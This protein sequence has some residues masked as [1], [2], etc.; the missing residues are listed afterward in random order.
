MNG[1]SSLKR[2]NRVVLL[3]NW[4]LNVILTLGYIVEYLKG[5][6]SLLFVISFILTFIIP[7]TIASFIYIKD[8]GSNNIKFFTLTGYFLMYIHAL[9]ASTRTLTFIY[10]F[11]VI[12][13]YLLYFDLSL[14]IVTNILTLVLNI[15]RVA[16]LVFWMGFSDSI[17][18]TDYTIQLASVALF[19]FS[20]IVTTKLSNSFNKEN[21]DNIKTE[22]NKQESILK[23][24]LRTAS[25]LDKNT[26]EVYKIV[27][28]LSVSTDIVA[29][30][31]NETAK[32]SVDNA[33]NIQTQSEL[34]YNIHSLI[35]DTSDLS[36]KMSNISKDTTQ[37]VFDG[38][39]IVNDV[40][41]AADI[42]NESSDNVYNSMIE[43]KNKTNEIQDIT[44][45]ITEIAEQTN[46]LSLN[47]SIES[48]RAGESG[49]G[50]AVVADEIRKLAEQSKQSASDISRIIGELKVKADLSVNASIKLKKVNLEQND[51]INQNKNIFDSILE[52][53]QDVNSTVSFVNEKIDEILNSNNKIVQSIS[54]I[55][56]VSEQATANM[57]ETS[58]LTSQ[59]IN[60]IKLVK[61]LV[62]ELVETSN[63]LRK[64]F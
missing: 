2:T 29:N 36:Q 55:S 13:M 58:A 32:G 35:S 20:L 30:S 53:M 10:F 7:M 6:K 64:Y 60:Q 50:F 8:K 3:N 51:L 46:L 9:F 43:L 23:D 62:D 42:V 19:G 34:T 4:V 56:S 14:I 11:P 41:Q 61:A 1:T 24:V 45:I 12:A 18:T 17:N 27:E 54:E 57:E 22:E 59:N 63:Q 44:K 31:I 28:D 37:S 49:K 5:S 39:S 47:A 25:I 40:S 26:N 52:K 33:L 16:F 38:I 48:A 21:L 15:A